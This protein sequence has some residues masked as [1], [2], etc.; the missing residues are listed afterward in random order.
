MTEEIKWLKEHYDITRTGRV[1]RIRD[2][3]ELI[4]AYDKKGYKRIRLK[5]ICSK[6]IDGGKTYKVHR[7]VAMYYLV[8]YDDSLQVNH[9]NG[10]KS[11]NRVE[12]LE[13]VTN[14]ENVVHA[15]RCLD[16]RGRLEKLNSH[17]NPITG[18]FDIRQK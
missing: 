1:I 12:N 14:R 15:W 10:N 3:K 9:K 5:S 6:H 2:N 11:D 16:K 13:M 18:R 17:R 7:L 4:P 8:D